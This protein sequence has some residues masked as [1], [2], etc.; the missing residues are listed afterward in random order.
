MKGTFTSAPTL[1]HFDQDKPR[2]IECDSSDDVNAGYLSQPDPEGILHQV[3]FFSRKL[4]PAEVNYDIYDKEL[5]AVVQSFEGW[6][7]ELEGAGTPVQVISDHK[8]LQHFMK[9]K[10]LTRRQGDRASF[11]PGLISNSS[12]AQGPRVENQML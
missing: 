6:R 8:N 3:A 9:T 4:S 7:A 12:I 1:R 5:M 10:R 11:Y 2:T